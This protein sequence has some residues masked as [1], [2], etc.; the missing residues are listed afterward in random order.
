[1]QV[2]WNRRILILNIFLFLSGR[3]EDKAGFV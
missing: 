2:I 1:M 3:G